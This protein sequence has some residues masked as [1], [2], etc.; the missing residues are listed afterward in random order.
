MPLTAVRSAARMVLAVVVGYGVAAAVVIAGS[1]TAAMVM[2]LPPHGPPTTPYLAANVAMSF[3]GA[4]A[5]GYACA[6]LA[7]EGRRVITIG[8][9]VLVFLAGAV[10]TWRSTPDV[11]QQPPGY[12][13][14]ISLLGVV[15]LWAGA[16]VERA[17]YGTS[18]SRGPQVPGS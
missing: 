7:P 3:M 4:V 10:V 8:L 12:L 1:L 14:L 5:A 11:A 9:L 15:G 2:G 17:R 16:M 18:S 13:P 6:R